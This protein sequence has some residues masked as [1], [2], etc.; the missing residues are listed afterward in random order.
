MPK[1][2]FC[3]VSQRKGITLTKELKWEVS[4][5]KIAKDPINAPCGKERGIIGKILSPEYPN[6]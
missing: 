6:T 3:T 2:K 1:V 5:W 4:N